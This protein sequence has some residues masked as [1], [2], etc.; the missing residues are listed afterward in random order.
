MEAVNALAQEASRSARAMDGSA[1]E[2]AQKAEELK[3]LANSV[4]EQRARSQGLRGLHRHG[5]GDHGD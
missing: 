3:G 1:A 5:Y 2:L 4:G